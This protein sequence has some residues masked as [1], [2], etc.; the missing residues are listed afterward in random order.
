MQ[1]YFLTAADNETLTATLK[2]VWETNNP[3]LPQGAA[4]PEYSEQGWVTHGFAWVTSPAVFEGQTLITP[5]V[6]KPGYHSLMRVH[7]GPLGPV[8]LGMLAAAGIEVQDAATVTN[9]PLVWR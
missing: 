5:P 8:S 2:F 9:P 1:D 4:P 7:S 6:L 3:P